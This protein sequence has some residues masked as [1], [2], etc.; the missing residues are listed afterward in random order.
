MGFRKEET[1]RLLYG[2]EILGLDPQS[3]GPSYTFEHEAMPDYELEG[4][5]AFSPR[6][7]DIILDALREHYDRL[8]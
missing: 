7:A 8:A 5:I 1:E 2:F 4:W 3:A 6:Q